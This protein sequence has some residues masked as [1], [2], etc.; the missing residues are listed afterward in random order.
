M[1][2][3]RTV[4]V[5]ILALYPLV[6]TH[7]E[8]PSKPYNVDVWAS[9]LFGVDGKITEYTITDEATYPAE[10]LK[11]I[12]SRL[13]NAKIQPPNES[14]MPVTLRTG[15]RLEFIVTPEAEERGQVRFS[16]VSMSPLPIKRYYASYP[17]DVRRSRGWEGQVEG[18]CT[19]GITGQCGSIEVKALPGIPESV[20][21]FIKVSLEGW[22][23]APQEVDGKPVEGEFALRLRL[24]T[25]DNMP[26]DFRQDKFLRI[27]KT[28]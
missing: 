4:L 10:F 3:A 1:H 17:K 25:L 23:F 16:R 18:I 20:R 8:E 27:L 11:N 26:E 2:Q 24:N 9:A 21:R 14:G 15:V 19:V 7:A 5:A 13:E 22:S 12:K 28:R 6:A